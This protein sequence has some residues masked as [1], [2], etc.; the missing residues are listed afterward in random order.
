VEQAVAT[1]VSS[2]QATSATSDTSTVRD[3][4]ASAKVAASKGRA[5]TLPIEKANPV[6]IPRFETAPV[7]N[8]NLDEEQWKSA[9]TLRD[10]YQTQ[11]GDNIAPSKPTEVYIGYDARFLYIAFKAFDEPDKIR[12]TIAKRDGIFEDDNVGFFL[13]TF[14]DQRKAYEILLNPHGIQADAI[15]TDNNED[16]SFDLVMESKGIITT[17][18]YTVEVAIPFK[19]LRYEAG[20][21]KNWG[22]HFF[23][24]I[25]RFNNELDSWMPLSRD[26]SGTLIQAGKITGLENISTE[27]TLEII[28][29][30]TISETGKRVR[31]FPPQPFPA[32]APTSFPERFVNKPLEAD[33]GLTAKFGLMPTVT[34][35][36]AYN[37]DFAQVEADQTVVTANQRFPIFFSEKRPFFLEGREIFETT[38]NVIHTRAI[39]DPDYA[40]KLTGKRGRNTFG[41]LYASDNAPGNYTEDERGEILN[42]K[43]C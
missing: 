14:N 30:L 2:S 24:R 38:S 40:V 10:F 42:S 8:G 22:V 13:D 34:L 6:R 7:I 37:P 31:S 25:K 41:V 26:I 4:A 29:S 11:P 39:V 36:F 33:F 1:P 15:Y 9:A 21:G 17:D 20:K 16:F 43:R 12:A 19:S 32:T 3:T 28:P 27:R 23:R 35:D 18:G 5:V